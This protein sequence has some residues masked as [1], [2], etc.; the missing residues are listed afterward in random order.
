[1]DFIVIN[2]INI[3]NVLY[4]NI[5]IDYIYVY[6]SFLYMPIYVYIDMSA[7]KDINAGEFSLWLS[8]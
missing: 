3:V 1:M 7:Y 4:I 8:G 6:N 5:A 2:I